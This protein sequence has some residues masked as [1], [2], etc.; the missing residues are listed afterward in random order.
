MNWPVWCQ[1][2]GRQ[3]LPV[4]RCRRRSDGHSRRSAVLRH[5]HTW[6]YKTATRPS[7]NC[8]VTQ[9]THT[10]HSS[11]TSPVLDGLLARGLHRE[12]KFKCKFK[13]SVTSD[14]KLSQCRERVFEQKRF[15][16]MLENVRVCYFLNWGQAV[17]SFR[18]SIGNTAFAKLQPS[19]QWEFPF[20]MFFRESLRNETMNEIFMQTPLLPANDG[21][22][23]TH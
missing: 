5:L 22:H 15:Q 2:I 21:A 7:S 4:R 6:P 19:C 13:L 9:D 8:T 14:K 10:W 17:P 12:F 11:A 20:S 18:P 3:T 1:N 16:F 23:V